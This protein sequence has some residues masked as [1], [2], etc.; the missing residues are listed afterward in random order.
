[1]VMVEKSERITMANLLKIISPEKLSLRKMSHV[2]QKE[3][4]M[5]NLSELFKILKEYEPEVYNEALLEPFPAELA[6]GNAVI[7]FNSPSLKYHFIIDE[8]LNIKIHA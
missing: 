4:K 5:S 1:M 8:E 6:F 2:R 3:V 7:E